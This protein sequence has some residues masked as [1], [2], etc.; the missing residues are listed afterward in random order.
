MQK[1]Y[2]LAPSDAKVI[3][4]LGLLYNQNKQTD[5]AIPLLEK[6]IQFKPDY[7]DAYFAL[8]TILH[9]TA[10]DKNNH[11]IDEAKQ[12]K[13]IE[14]LHFIINTL[15]PNDKQARETLKSWGEK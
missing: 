3:Y 8:A 15:S 2:A 5:K 10:V 14:Y 7:R 1:A 11:V 9:E 12:K 13:A 4:N 6:T